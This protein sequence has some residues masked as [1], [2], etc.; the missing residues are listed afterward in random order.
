MIAS[1]LTCQPRDLFQRPHVV[2][3]SG[4]H[5]RLSNFFEKAFVN[6]VNRRMLTAS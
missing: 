3:L 2:R 5:R 1:R 4:F 6:R